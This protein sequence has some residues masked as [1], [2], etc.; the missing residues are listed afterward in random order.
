MVGLSS[1]PIPGVTAEAIVSEVYC[2]PPLRTLTSI[3]CPS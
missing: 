1:T 3:T 2:S